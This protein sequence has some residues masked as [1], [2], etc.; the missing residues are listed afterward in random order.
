M[1]EDRAHRAQ[2]RARI[3]RALLAIDPRGLGGAVCVR[4][5]HEEVRAFSASLQTLLGEGR[6]LRRLPPGITD[7]RLY[8]GLD[9]TASLATG[10]RVAMRG[11]LSETNGGV[12]VVPLAERSASSVVTALGEVLDN[13]TITLERDGITEQQAAKLVV[14][15]IDEEADGPDDVRLAPALADRLAFRLLL[16]PSDTHADDVAS[17]Q[18]AR[19]WWPHVRPGTSASVVT[20]LAMSLGVDSMRAALQA[21]RTARAHAAWRGR[22]EVNDEDI[23][24]A[25]ELVLV[26]RATRAPEQAEPPSPPDESPDDQPAPPDGAQ[27]NSDI[28]QDLLLD[29]VRALL[30]PD[31]LDP[32]TALRR[33][34]AQ[35]GRRGRE[36]RGGDRGRQVRATPG[37]PGRGLRLD[38]VATLRTAA[39]WQL[40]RQRQ[41]TGQASRL[42]VSRDDFRIRRFKRQAGTT[43]IIAV[44]ASGSMAL[45]RLAEA[46]GAVEL[47]L[48]RTYVRR[49]RVALVVFRGERAVVLLPPTRALARAKRAILS[50]PGGGGTPLASA[51]EQIHLLASEAQRDG[52]D[53]VTVLLTDGKA[54][55][56][57]DG[58][59]G[60]ERAV[61]DALRAARMLR[62][63]GTH[64]VVVD[65]SM[66]GE[67]RARELAAALG[68]RYVPL[69]DAAARDVAL[70]VRNERTVEGV[71]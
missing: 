11:V 5:R 68:G 21:M 1:T 18:A 34:T 47:L 61:A 49:D 9:L 26:P 29:A 14:V 67:P 8:G 33:K 52:Q 35:A 63:L 22:P 13:G 57:R 51:I 70:A 64:S 45:Q 43:T 66:R 46:K 2:E 44:D 15:A 30:P 23:V 42:H 24:V 53:V 36:Q 4:S 7:D 38:A 25:A 48:A 54:N 6:P 71:P 31:L 41:A 59:P 28:P 56:A 32:D 60:R 20:Q 19:A 58:Q 40:V 37:M 69:P 16:E 12:L 10:R 55:I 17:V 50:L 39:P 27:E 3:A 62:L 65:T